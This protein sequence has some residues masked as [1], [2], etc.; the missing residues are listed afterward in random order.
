MESAQLEFADG[1]NASVAHAP[2]NT[3]G[4]K[5]HPAPNSAVRFRFYP[6]DAQKAKLLTKTQARATLRNWIVD[7]FD[8]SYA[9]HLG[10]E[11]ARAG[12]T[13]ECTP[14]ALF[15]EIKR[16]RKAGG[17]Q[18]L[19]RL[20]VWSCDQ[21]LDQ[22]FEARKRA[23]EGK[24]RHPRRRPV[25]A[26]GPGTW[27]TYYNGRNGDRYYRPE[28]TKDADGRVK[29]QCIHLSGIGPLRVRTGR[30]HLPE[31]IERY[32]TVTV[33]VDACGRWTASFGV[34]KAVERE[35]PDV[36]DRDAIVGLDFGLSE[37]V[38]TDSGATCAAAR[39]LREDERKKRLRNNARKGRARAER[40]GHATDRGKLRKARR[41]AKHAHRKKNKKEIY[42]DDGEIARKRK[43]TKAEK[44][45]RHNVRV[46]HA[47]AARAK[48]R[49][50]LESRTPHGAEQ[51]TQKGNDTAKKNR[52][53]RNPKVKSRKQGAAS[54]AR[55]RRG[56][57]RCDAA[58]KHQRKLSRRF[59]R[60]RKGSKG[61][62]RARL[63]LAQHH[64]QVADHRANAIHQL[65]AWLVSVCVALAWEDLGVKSLL[66]AWNAKA[67]HDAAIG[68]CKRQLAY[69]TAQRGVAAVA[70][71]RYFPSSQ[72]CSTCGWRNRAL[73]LSQKYWTCEQCGTRH[74]R[75]ENAAK[76][77]AEYGIGT[78]QSQGKTIR[79][80]QRTHGLGGTAVTSA[81]AN[82]RE[83]PESAQQ[84]GNMPWR[85][86]WR[87]RTT[88]GT[89]TREQAAVKADGT[90]RP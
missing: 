34:V 43:A 38:T 9:R 23:F 20:S 2:K 80:K 17:H 37:L 55:R 42:A 71:S 29:G 76:N 65:T 50:A 60:T 75:D 53:G 18:W 25:R 1:A 14:K 83:R 67:L 19:R 3:G 58:T 72:L 16:V 88:S 45:R 90:P 31:H 57:T 24:G 89:W 86:P 77:N 62:E 41:A 21:V 49:E 59:S 40:C 4:R 5:D 78:W 44:L 30:G 11:E 10:N 6:T 36:L 64:A 61:R 12:L 32:P 28:R 26:N 68:E 35:E 27:S 63:V 46:K 69:K 87:M 74:Q 70:C 81:G 13:L 7:V 51:N 54:N 82:T 22:L 33:R 79:Y 39:H 73:T 66:N 47:R 48:K 84:V 15:D 8:R 56:R 85:K 52:G